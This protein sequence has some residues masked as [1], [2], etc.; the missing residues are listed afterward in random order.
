MVC[1]RGVKLPVLTL[2]SREGAYENS[3]RVLAVLF[4]ARH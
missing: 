4:A 1:L 3:R 2:L